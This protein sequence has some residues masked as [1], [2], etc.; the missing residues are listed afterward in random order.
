MANA[1]DQ[2]KM[3]GIDPIEQTRF[4]VLKRDGR[5]EEFNEARI[6]LAIESAF[7]SV[8]G[9]AEDQP[10]SDPASTRMK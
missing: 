7:R 4:L 1:E 5:K 8:E 6:H 9:L 2:I 3:I 10:L